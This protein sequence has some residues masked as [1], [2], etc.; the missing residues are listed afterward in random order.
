MPVPF[1]TGETTASVQ[2]ALGLLSGSLKG[3]EETET[4]RIYEVMN[5]VVHG[6]CAAE[7][8]LDAALWEIAGKRAG[9]PLCR[10]QGEYR[11]SI[12]DSFTVDIGEADEVVRFTRE[13]IYSGLNAVKVKPGRGLSEDYE[14][15]KK[16]GQMAGED[17]TIYVGFSQSYSAKRA[18]ELPPSM[19]TL[20]IEFFERPT[21]AHDIAGL[22]FATDH[23]DI[24]VMADEAAYG[25]EDTMKTVKHEAADI[26]N[27]ELMNA[28]GITMGRKVIEMVEAAGPPAM[29]VCTAETEIAATAGAHPASGMRNPRYAEPDGCSSLVRNGTSGIECTFHCF[30]HVHRRALVVMRRCRREIGKGML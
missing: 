18:G 26:I 7:C 12:P 1:I 29:T 15:V 16:A 23:S 11:Y 2:E 17:A 21:P 25:P 20:G 28:G 9:P 10:L 24:P 19:H 4:E 14:R 3:M 27:L 5:R 30:G 13:F 6:S 8:G 22:K